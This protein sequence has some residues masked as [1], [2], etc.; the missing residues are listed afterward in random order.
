MSDLSPMYKYLRKLSNNVT[1]NFVDFFDPVDLTLFK[2]LL[3]NKVK[4]KEWKDLVLRIKCDKIGIDVY[5]KRL[6][7]MV[8]EGLVKRTREGYSLSSSGFLIAEYYKNCLQYYVENLRLPPLLRGAL[9]YV[10]DLDKYN[11]DM[12]VKSKTIYD[13]MRNDDAVYLHILSKIGD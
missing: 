12:N 8:R 3:D 7:F 5:K 4:T 2:H 13:I 1:L 9:D 11:E 6:D 10:F